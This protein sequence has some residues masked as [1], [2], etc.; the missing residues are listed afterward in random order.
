[1]ISA[2]F[3]KKDSIYKTLGVDCFDV[4]RDARTWMGGNSII[5]HPPC[6]AW[7]RLAQFAKPREDERALAVLS[8]DLIRKWGG[9][10]EHPYGS[11]LWNDLQI[12]LPMP[13][14]RDVFGGFTICINQSW[15]G[16]KAQ[17]KTM[18]YIVGCS[19]SDLPNLP[20]S[21]DA[22]EYV[23]RPSKNGRGAKI[24]TKREREATPIAFAKWLIETA[25][26]CNETNKKK[27]A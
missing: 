27:I 4:D 5:C 3:V 21:F 8:V 13:G 14:Q 1:M 23:V 19:P 12:N 18:L 22:I 2:L 6:R 24:I 11:T 26:I 25:T 7:G 16:H 17:K 9:V 15:F 10:L 20:I